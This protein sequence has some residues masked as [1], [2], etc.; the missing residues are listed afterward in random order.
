MK[1]LLACFP[2]FCKC[3]QVKTLV[4]E[5]SSPVFCCRENTQSKT[6]ESRQRASFGFLL[7]GCFPSCGIVCPEHQRQGVNSPRRAD[8]LVEH[9]HNDGIYSVHYDCRR[10]RGLI[11]LLQ[12][13]RAPINHPASSSSKWPAVLGELANNLL[14]AS[15]SS[16]WWF[17]CRKSYGVSDRRRIKKASNKYFSTSSRQT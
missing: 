2:A 15:A 10:A 12:T 3:F 6:S 16:F 1:S 4:W 14:V 7:P 5:R 11:S 8:S 13:S 17:L 9:L